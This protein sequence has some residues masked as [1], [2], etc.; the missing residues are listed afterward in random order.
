M[1]HSTFFAG[2]L[3]IFGL[4]G[5]Y[6]SSAYALCVQPQE[7]GSWVNVDNNTRSI[8]R[9]NIRFQCQDVILN[10]QPYPPGSPFYIKLFGSCHPNDCAWQ[11][12]G[13]E[14]ASGGWKLGHINQ[15]FAKRDIWFK[16]YPNGRLR[17]FIRTDFVD[18]GRRDYTSDDWFVRR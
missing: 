5:F 16:T 18:P 1:K 11:E 4:F 10:G 2:L 15:G 12:V 9:A 7:E 6:T 3:L 17:V 8:T 14:Y 13:A